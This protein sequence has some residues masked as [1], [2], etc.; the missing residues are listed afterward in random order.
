MNEDI[1]ARFALNE[2]KSFGG[3]KPLHRSCFF[4]VY[5]YLSSSLL[6]FPAAFIQD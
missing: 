3:V 4:H 5:L 1:F 2:S 6:G